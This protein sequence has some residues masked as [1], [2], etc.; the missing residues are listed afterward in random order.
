[1]DSNRRLHDNYESNESNVS[2]TTASNADLDTARHREINP[3]I[4]PSDELFRFGDICNNNSRNYQHY[5]SRKTNGQRSGSAIN[6][7][8]DSNQ[9]VE[10]IFETVLSSFAANLREIVDFTSQ[11]IEVECNQM[12]HQIK[13]VST[14]VEECTLRTNNRTNFFVSNL[15]SNINA[16]R[17]QTEQEGIQHI[18]NPLLDSASRHEGEA[19]SQNSDSNGTTSE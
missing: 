11:H 3:V 7:H 13:E 15:L 8:P 6:Q 10:P 4:C 2:S 16:L 19:E 14:Y 5:V 17:H 18:E 1:M 9:L 12:S